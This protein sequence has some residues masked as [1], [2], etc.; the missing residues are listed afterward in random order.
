MA[1]Q[2]AAWL[3]AIAVGVVSSGLVG[4]LWTLATDEEPRLRALLD[5]N[6]G[7][8]TPLRVLA[9]VFSAPTTIFMQGFADLIVRPVIGVPVLISAFVWSFLQGVFILTRVFGLT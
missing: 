8:L 4:T 3:L 5:P 6:P 1:A 2:H 7:P 9:I